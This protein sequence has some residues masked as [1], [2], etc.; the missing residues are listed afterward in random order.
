MAMP[1]YGE[2]LF[3]QAK[4]MQH[5]YIPF[6]MLLISSALLILARHWLGMHS[7]AGLEIAVNDTATVCPI[8]GIG[9]LTTNL[10]DLV[11]GK[12]PTG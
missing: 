10:Q 3:D 2:L 4:G 9:Y 7:V 11:Y 5:C 1:V 12:R 6:F 8:E